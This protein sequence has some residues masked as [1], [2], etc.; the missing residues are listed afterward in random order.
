MNK[1]TFNI[2]ITAT[3]KT[4]AESKMKSLCALVSKL[5]ANELEKLADVVL[6]QPAKMAIA[7]KAMGL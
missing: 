7:K 2:H 1:F 4:E 5:K 3:D 6:N